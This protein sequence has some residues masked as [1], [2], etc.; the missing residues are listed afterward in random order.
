MIP[1]GKTNQM[2]E[3]KDEVLN[4]TSSPLYKY[5]SENNFLPVIGEGNHDADIMFIGEAPGKNE[6]LTGRPFCGASGKVLDELLESVNLKRADV[7]ITNIVK[8]RPPGNRDPLPEEI[9]FYAPFLERQIDIIKPK[10][11]ATLGRFSMTFILERYGSVEQNKTIG[12]L[13]GQQVRISTNFGDIIL[14]PLYHPAASIYN[15][16]LKE[17]LMTDIKIVKT[18][19]I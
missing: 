13:H 5:R 17:S 6:A 14:V 10:I 16:H 8:D 11:I 7:Y 3:I 4:L 12:E 2:K 15:R 18:L 19:T 9:E 1:L